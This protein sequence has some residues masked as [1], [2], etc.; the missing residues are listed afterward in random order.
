MRKENISVEREV[1]KP[2]NSSNTKARSGL[3]L[4]DQADEQEES[5]KLDF[6][7]PKL[8]D[9]YSRYK[10]QESG[11]NM[12]TQRSHQSSNRASTMAEVK[13]RNAL[14]HEL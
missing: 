12:T 3:R 8:E 10:N 7:S 6:M 4:K 11:S 13:Q 9:V 14:Q 1:K 5:V 2:I